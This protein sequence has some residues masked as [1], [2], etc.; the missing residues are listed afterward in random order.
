MAVPGATLEPTF[1]TMVNVTDVPDA[2]AVPEHVVPVPGQQVI[3]P[4]FPA[5]GIVGQIQPAGSEAETKVVFNGTES[6]RA[7]LEALDGPLFF[8]TYVNVMLLPASTGFGE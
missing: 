2:T 6:L 7:T 8:S 4:V 1:S 5:V 3:V